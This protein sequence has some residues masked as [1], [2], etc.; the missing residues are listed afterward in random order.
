MQLPFLLPFV[1][2]CLENP[3]EIS[4]LLSQA[5]GRVIA[6]Y[7]LGT[8]K[9]HSEKGQKFGRFIEPKKAGK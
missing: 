1:Q 6:G 3:A 7:L 5:L 9:A 4:T 8:E 2:W